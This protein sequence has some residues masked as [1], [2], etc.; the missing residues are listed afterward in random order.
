MSTWVE[1]WC[2]HFS[3]RA[4]SSIQNGV[5]R[6][7]DADVVTFLLIYCRKKCICNSLKYHYSKWFLEG[8][9]WD[10]VTSCIELSLKNILRF[11]HCNEIQNTREKEPKYEDLYT[12]YINLISNI[13]YNLSL[14]P[15]FIMH[16]F[17]RMHRKCFYTHRILRKIDSVVIIMYYTHEFSFCEIWYTSTGVLLS[18]RNAETCKLKV[19]DLHV[20]YSF[21]SIS[22]IFINHRYANFQ[23]SC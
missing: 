15:F 22:K 10:I 16:A 11:F 8:T 19:N 1:H 17:I 18:I 20:W 7:V 6:L 9:H 23:N 12:D 3:R 5:S 21:T 14:L 2:P 4:L 13:F